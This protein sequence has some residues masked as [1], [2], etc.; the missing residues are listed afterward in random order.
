MVTREC[1]SNLIGLRSDL[2]SDIFEGC[3]AASQPKIAIYV[4]NNNI[5][6]LDL[7]RN[8][9]DDTLF[10]FCSNDQYCNTSI[11]IKASFILIFIAYLSTKLFID[12]L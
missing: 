6:E 11:P 7:K 5:K 10:C 1:L 2:P 3:R 8:Y 12:F 4:D 9:Y